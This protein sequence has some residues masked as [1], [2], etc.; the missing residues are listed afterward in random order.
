MSL[1]S[2]CGHNE[3]GK[4]TGGKPGDQT[5]GEWAL[6]PWYSRPWN[7]VL[8]HPDP[9]VRAKLSELAKK[10]AK[11][12]LVGYCQTHRGTYW[13]HL[14]ASH[15]DPSQITIACEADCSSGVMSN[16]RAVGY[17]LN[18]SSFKKVSLVST[19][20]MRKTLK[21]LG[22]EVLTD[23]KYLTGPNWLLEGDILLYEGHHTATN[24][25]NGSATGKKH[26]ASSG[27]SSESGSSGSVCKKNVKLGQ[28]WLNCNYGNTLVKYRG[29]KL[30]TDGDYGTKSRAG[31]LAVWKYLVNKKFG[32]A[33]TPSN[34]AFGESCKKIAGKALVKNGTQGTFTYL[35]QFILAAKGYYS[36]RMDAVCGINLSVTITA[37]QRSEGLPPDGECGADTWYS[38]FN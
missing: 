6:I 22:F 21:S 23:S 9:K 15:Y 3:S 18:I 29:A 32:A 12:N 13:T 36:G 11:N 24:C 31:A 34:T 7:V 27:T 16:I 2:N 33:L 19:S 14:K 25:E 8:R 26:P 37:Y 38:L 4:L 30:A 20:S 5:G 17:L 28:E 1:I 35:C 10:A